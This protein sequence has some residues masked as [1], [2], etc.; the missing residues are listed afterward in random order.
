VTASLVVVA[1][2]G[3]SALAPAKAAAAPAK[4]SLSVWTNL[5]G[6][7]ATELKTI[8]MAYQK[9]NPGVS[10]DF[11]APGANYEQ[12]MITK[13]AANKDMPDVFSTHGWAKIRY[14]NFLADLS[15]QPWA[16]KV[17]PTIKSAIADPGPNGKLY[18]LPIDWEKTGF[19][20]NVSIL[21]QY[22]IAVPKTIQ[23]FQQAMATIKAKSNGKITPFH[24]GAADSWMM[25]QVF[26]VW[27]TS[28]LVSPSKNYVT[29]LNNHTFNWNNFLTLPT[30]IQSWMKAGYINKDVN[31]AHFTDTEKALANGTA[32]FACHGTWMVADILK[33]NPKAQ[34][35]LMPVPSIVAGDSPTFA[36]GEQ[37]TWGVWNKSKNLQAAINFVNY[38]AQPANIQAVC[39]VTGLPSGLTGISVDLGTMVP[40]YKQYSNIR[41]FTYFDRLYLPN[42][43][44]DP[45]CKN[46][47][48][49]CAMSITPQQFCNNMGKTYSSL[50][51]AQASASPAS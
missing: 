26:D 17:D 34:I 14:G 39:K 12:I 5:V 48:E 4:V 9:A 11:E 25:G 47:Q 21:K 33:M 51:A 36:G 45:L 15:K 18:V 1:T 28:L 2:A 46:G 13:M 7:Q 30:T 40:Y 31:S 22:N 23:Q 35:G 27:A 42:G 32:A 29:S 38:Y 41:S 49:L 43:A 6:D 50:W 3:I 37:M 10:I 16:S 24:I 20:Y 8:A 44:W 19:L